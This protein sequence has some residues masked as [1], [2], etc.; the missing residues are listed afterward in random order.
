MR[1]SFR[2]ASIYIRPFLPADS[3]LLFSAA[4]ESIDQLCAWMTWCSPAYSPE[5]SNAFVARAQAE[6]ENGASHYFAILDSRDDSLLGSVGLSGINRTHK[7]ANLGIWVRSTRTRQGVAAAATRLIAAFA[8]Q[9]LLLSRLEILVAAENKASLRVAEKVGAK[10]EGVLR[11]RLTLMGKLHDAI[12][13][14]LIPAD[15]PGLPGPD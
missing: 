4:R 5:D 2:T 3:P 14:S 7:L 11:S 9:E 8:F 13:C 12:L 15:L 1:T 6:W 10:T